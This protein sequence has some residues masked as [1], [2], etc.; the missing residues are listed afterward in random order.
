MLHAAMLELP[1]IP[2][3]CGL[4]PSPAHVA[5]QTLPRS[6]EDWHDTLNRRM[7]EHDVVR[8]TAV[9]KQFPL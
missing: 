7:R 5:R 4:L 3:Q 2:P 9:V 8:F 6:H 1:H